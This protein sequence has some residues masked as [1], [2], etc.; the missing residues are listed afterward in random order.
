LNIRIIIFLCLLISLFY[1]SNAK[2]DETGLQSNNILSRKAI[3]W[4]YP[5]QTTDC[6]LISIKANGIEISKVEAQ[7]Q[8]NKRFIPLN[9][10][11]RI[12]FQKKKQDNL[13]PAN[14]S[15]ILLENGDRVFASIE[16]IEDDYV[17]IKWDKQE[18][19]LQIPLETVRAILFNYS[20]KDRTSRKL[21]S[22]VFQANQSND[23]F[24][25]VNGDTISGELKKMDSSAVS[26]ESRS[27]LRSISRNQI[28]AIIMN[29]ELISFPEANAVHQLVQF[30]N[31]SWL[32]CHAIDTDENN[33]IHFE[34]IAGMKFST[35]LEA[36]KSITFLSS[37]VQFLSALKQVQYQHVPYLSQHR[38]LKVNRNNH[39][40]FLQL[41]D[42]EYP[43][44]LGMYSQ[45]SVTYQLSGQFQ[46]LHAY[47]GIDQSA[48]KYGSVLFSVEA[49][50]R[51]IYESPQVT[52]A[53]S[54]VEIKELIL[55]HCN[56]LKLNVHFGEFGDIQ[57]L[58]NW[59]DL[60]L[61]K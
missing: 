22:K 38:D 40:L 32:N 8:E 45:S 26:L 53:T 17:F 50:R 41:G 44:G 49:D 33:K 25:L 30:Q 1:A 9:D 7:G 54:P 34:A 18:I 37:R 31:G 52:R 57:D 5:D 19:F 51:K 21:L 46:R 12:S 58:A 6:N 15:L 48:G 20:R 14:S 3:V 11:V 55:D 4:E 61:I 59:C 29:R 2:T 47:L 60:L 10:L 23:Y 24:Y 36:I 35:G 42:V 13:H 43:T 16:K 39:D 28:A 27:G 56:E